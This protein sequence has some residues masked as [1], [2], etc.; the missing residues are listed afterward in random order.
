[1]TVLMM[2]RYYPGIMQVLEGDVAPSQ[3]ISE[4]EDNWQPPNGQVSA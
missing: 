2:D 3:A 1:M 4:I